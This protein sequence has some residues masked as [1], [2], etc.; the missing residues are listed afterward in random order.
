M[1]DA[2]NKYLGRYNRRKAKHKNAKIDNREDIKQR[3]KEI[4][5]LIQAIG[6]NAMASNMNWLDL[7]HHEEVDDEVLRE[8]I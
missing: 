4:E 8:Q 6:N 7:E 2:G 3:L 5:D 1:I